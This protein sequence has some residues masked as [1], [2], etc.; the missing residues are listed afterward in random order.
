LT[1]QLG[2]GAPCQEYRSLRPDRILRSKARKNVPGVAPHPNVIVVLKSLKQIVS[3]K[4]VR[5]GFLE[6]DRLWTFGRL[7]AEN[8]RRQQE[9]QGEKRDRRGSHG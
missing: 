9:R 6:V 2:F 3:R 1:G 5:R 4:I 8:G 7:K